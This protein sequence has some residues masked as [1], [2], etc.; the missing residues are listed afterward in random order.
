VNGKAEVPIIREGCLAGVKADSDE[1]RCSFGPFVPMQSALC[2][3]GRRDRVR[4]G[5]ESHEER[6]TLGVYDLPAELAEDSAQELP[7]LG[8][9][10]AIAL[11]AETLQELSRPLDV[12][13]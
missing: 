4:G 13:E 3:H 11:A 8:E 12:C 7:V 2:R 1:E 10:E 9:D 5:T 6:I